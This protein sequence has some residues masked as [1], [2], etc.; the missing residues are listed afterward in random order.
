M[1]TVRLGVFETNSSSTHSITICKKEDYDKWVNNENVF[2]DNYGNIHVDE[3]RYQKYLKEKDEQYYNDD[4]YYSSRTFEQYI[5]NDRRL[6]NYHENYTSESG[7]E[8]VI[9]GEYG[10]DY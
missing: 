6:E 3:E 5:N 2:M 7:D 4:N 1:R 10:T 9:F 8:I